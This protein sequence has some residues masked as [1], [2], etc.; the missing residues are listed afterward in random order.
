MRF[1][2]IAGKK[3]MEIERRVPSSGRLSHPNT[4][5]PHF[6]ESSRDVQGISI[7]DS[8]IGEPDEK[9]ILDIINNKRMKN[10]TWDEREKKSGHTNI[11]EMLVKLKFYTIFHVTEIRRINCPTKILGD[12]SGIVNFFVRS[13]LRWALKNGMEPGICQ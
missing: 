9:T 7:S 10:K 8:G 5:M 6:L 12:K 2:D 1:V 11:N 13:S 4:Q 3:E